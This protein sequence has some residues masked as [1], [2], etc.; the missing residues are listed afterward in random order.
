MTD[1]YNSMWEKLN[2][3]LDAHAALLEVLGK[4][5]G[6]IYL[7]QEKRLKGMEYIDFVISEIH[8]LRIR[9]LQ[10]AKANGQK[11]VGTFCIF[12]PEEIIWAADA[13]AIGLCAGA[14]AGKEKAEEI[15]PRNLCSLIKSFVGFKLS[16]LCP[17][18]ESCDL[19]VGETTCDG[20][21]KAY[22]IFGDYVPMYVMEIPQMKRSIDKELWRKEIV[23]FKDKIESLTG[24][25][26]TAENLGKA[27]RI[28]ND[29]RR[30]LQRLNNLRR[31][32]PAPISGRDALLVNQISFY[33]DPKRFTQQINKLCDEIEDRVKRGDSIVPS[34]AVRIMVSGCPMAIPNWKL[35]YVV[36]SSGAVIVF[37]ESCV[38][39]RNTRDLVEESSKSLDEWIDALVDRYSR[40][41]CACFTPNEERIDNII[42]AAK[43]WEVK[44]VIHYHLN[45]CQPYEIESFKI[46][47]ILAKEGIP[48]I[49]VGTDYNMEDIEQLRTRIEAF[50]EILRT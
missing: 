13:I 32:H 31:H 9:E 22:E 15:L 40:I 2:L 4:F 29:R 11:V 14:E 5:Y 18:F 43:E 41:N 46:G 21:K 39:S 7:S 34:E 49:S 44:G 35:H 48:F 20:K 23:R 12:V 36:E 24:R 26:I 6:D 38:G 8:G 10:E 16:R 25:E 27:V 45:F 42:Q 1:L 3:D 33:D 17:F 47:R 28:I 30:A 19:I 50:L 37:E